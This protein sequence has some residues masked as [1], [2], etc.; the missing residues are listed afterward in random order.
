LFFFKKQKR[1]ARS[2]PSKYIDKKKKIQRKRGGKEPDP[3]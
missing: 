3:Q 1:L 2:K